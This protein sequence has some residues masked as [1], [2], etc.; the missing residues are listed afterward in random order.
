MKRHTVLYLLLI[1]LIIMNGFF[2]FNY[3]GR[4][5]Q[6]GPKASG[7]FIVTELKFND[8]QLAQFKSLEAKH[9]NNMRAV[10]DAIKSLKDQLF[11]NITAAS[12]DQQ[13]IDN[14]IANIADKTITR[15]HEL[16]KRLRAIYNLSDDK[17]KEQFKSIIKKARRFDNQGPEHPN[18]P[19]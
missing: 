14:L 3:I 6:N 9:H 12:I 19:D 13:E 15:E 5:G 10:G 18:R 11:S 17:Q 7:D 4:P 2:L 8:Q 16:F 1:V